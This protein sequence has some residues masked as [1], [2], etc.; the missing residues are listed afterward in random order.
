[1]EATALESAQAISHS[2]KFKYVPSSRREILEL[3]NLRSLIPTVSSD[4]LI[5]GYETY[6]RLM[7][8]SR[9]IEHTCNLYYTHQ[10]SPI[11][12]QKLNRFSKILVMN[13][14]LKSKMLTEGVLESKIQ[15]TYGAIDKQKFGPSGEIPKLDT[16]LLENYVLFSSDCKYRKNPEKVLALIASMPDIQFVIHGKSWKLHYSKKISDLPNL[17]YIEFDFKIQPYLMRSASAFVS[18]SSLEGGPYPLL[19]ALASGTPVVASRTGFSEDFV[20]PTNGYI[21]E[22]DDNLNKI[23]L[24]IR[25]ALRLKKQ[26]GGS[27]LT[28]KDLSW[29]RLGNDLYGRI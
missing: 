6:L 13:G 8:Y 18:L 14:S 12:S 24:C 22:H 25:G 16:Q 15:I 27:D 21:V 3:R 7:K 9:V 28:K 17:K 10:N 26:A 4:S 29:S 23:S 5:M 1:M 20:D 19:E 2:P 11:E